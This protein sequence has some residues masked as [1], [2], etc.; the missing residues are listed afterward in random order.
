M[1]ANLFHSATIHN[2][3][4]NETVK[5]LRDYGRSLGIRGLWKK[6]KEQLREH[7]FNSVF[8]EVNERML[9]RPDMDPAR[10]YMEAELSLRSKKLTNQKTWAKLKDEAQRADV[11][12]NRRSKKSEVER[13]IIKKD[14]QK[15]F[16]RYRKVRTKK[17]LL[18]EVQDLVAHVNLIED[19]QR[20]KRIEIKGNLNNVS[21]KLIME[22]LTP[23]IE[24]RVKV[25]YS[26]TADIY[27][28]AGE[29][30]EYKKTIENRGLFTSLE[31]IR[32]YIEDC[33]QKRLDLENDEV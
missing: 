1:T 30:T 14:S 6:N 9:R 33:E 31:E 22:K 24:M 28:G 4:M 5:E 23:H 19:G 2:K 11:I 17:S 25:L 3:K 26:F 15:L 20:V 29:V 27:R 16:K 21:T 8:E 7:I 13:Q 18:K 10:A 32:N 12:V